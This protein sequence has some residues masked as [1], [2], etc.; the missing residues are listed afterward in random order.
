MP[1]PFRDVSGSKL[2]RRR[3]SVASDLEYLE[4]EVRCRKGYLAKI[5]RWVGESQRPAPDSPLLSAPLRAALPLSRRREL[6]VRVRVTLYLVVFICKYNLAFILCAP[7]TDDPAPPPSLHRC[8]SGACAINPRTQD[9]PLADLHPRRCFSREGGRLACGRH[10][11]VSH[12]GRVLACK[13]SKR[14]RGMALAWGSARSGVVGAIVR[15]GPDSTSIVREMGIARARRA[16]TR[17]GDALRFPL[18]CCWDIVRWLSSAGT[19]HVPASRLLYRAVAYLNLAICRR[20]RTSG[21]SK[22]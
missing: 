9:A 3:H 13:G 22:H 20:L 15:Q 6:G 1:C 16:P 4:V 10:D 11:A 12:I 18:I 14:I 2:V 7:A 8:C 17:I 21:A 5:R 19:L